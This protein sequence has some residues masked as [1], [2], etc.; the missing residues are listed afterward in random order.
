MFFNIVNT[1]ICFKNMRVKRY[2]IRTYFNYFETLDKFDKRELL[3]AF[4]SF[5]SSK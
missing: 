4:L 5:E 3:A 2:I 1:Y